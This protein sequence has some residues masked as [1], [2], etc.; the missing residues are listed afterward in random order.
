MGNPTTAEPTPASVLER[1]RDRRFALERPAKVYRPGARQFAP[2]ITRDLSRSGVRIEVHT[3]RPA[4]VGERVRVAIAL[5]GHSLIAGD[6]FVDA[7]IV[8]AGP[9]D[10]TRQELALRYDAG[11]SPHPHVG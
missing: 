4:V 10:G 7:E 11:D 2:A 8:R 9:L 3:S 6:Q 1:R 5:R